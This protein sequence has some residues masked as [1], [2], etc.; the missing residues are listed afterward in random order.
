VVSVNSHTRIGKESGGRSA[1]KLEASTA[2]CQSDRAQM[3][4]QL[5]L[6][7]VG[8]FVVWAFSPGVAAFGNIG[9]PGVLLRNVADCQQCTYPVIRL[10]HSPICALIPPRYGTS[11]TL[12]ALHFLLNT[13]FAPDSPIC[14]L[15][16]P[17]PLFHLCINCASTACKM[18]HVILSLYGY[19]S[20]I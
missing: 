14:A 5:R 10:S 15:H 2:M 16:S 3:H 1:L 17:W 11:Q 18:T 4:T 20:F 19:G 7:C 12:L 8:L 6:A 13:V 9:R